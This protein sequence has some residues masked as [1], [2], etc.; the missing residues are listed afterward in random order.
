MAEK[1]EDESQALFV[2]I[3][4]KQ[5]VRVALVGGAIGLITWGLTIAFDTYL[6]KGVLC[7]GATAAKCA[8]SSSYANAAASVLAAGFGLL[9]FVRLQVFRAL[10]VIIATTL[11]LWG[12]PLLLKGWAWPQALIISLVLYTFTYVLFVWLARVRM[13]VVALLFIVI[14]VVGIR[15]LLN[16]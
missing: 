13:F 6:F 4:L 10:L 1:T 8:T 2:S 7:H 14:A 11:A 5:L 9:V 16:S 15:L 3:S 12:V